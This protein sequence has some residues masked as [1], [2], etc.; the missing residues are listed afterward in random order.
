MKK[1]YTPP[2][3][4]ELQLHTEGEVALRLASEGAGRLEN[5][6]DFLSNRHEGWQSE[7]WEGKEE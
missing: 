6:G 2:F 3:S 7:S 1:N 5:T 4:I